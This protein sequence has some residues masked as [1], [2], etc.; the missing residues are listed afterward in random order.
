MNN[1]ILPKDAKLIPKDADLV[2][3]GE[4]FSVYQWPQK[5][6]DGSIV[7]F[8]MAKRPDTVQIIGIDGSNI[9]VLNEYQPDGTVRKNSLPG[10]R[11]DP[12]ETNP[13]QAA[14]REMR[15][16][17]GYVFKHWKLLNVYQPQPK[18]EWFVYLYVAW[19]IE[20]IVKQK[21]DNGEKIEVIQAPW[22]LYLKEAKTT[23]FN[24]KLDR[25][26]SINEIISAPKYA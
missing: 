10:G 14:K 7:N 13:L 1:R 2:F 25:Y 20:S 26:K 23:V 9:I 6:Y 11:V 24:H 18:T 22:T 5:M 15:E 4:I 3:V 12:G 17:T 19:D 8:E 21:I 16:E